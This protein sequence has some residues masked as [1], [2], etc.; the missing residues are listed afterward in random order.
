MAEPDGITAAVLGK[1]LPADRFNVA[2]PS[3]TVEQ[4][5]SAAVADR[6]EVVL[7]GPGFSRAGLESVITTLLAA[8]VRTLVL[9]GAALDEVSSRLLL[10]GASGFLLVDD[11][12]PESVADAVSTVAT[13]ST[14]LHPDVI[15]AVLQQ[16]RESR[17]APAAGR[18]ERDVH[19]AALTSRESEVLQGLM[20]GLTSR[21]L[22]NRLGVAEKTVEAHKSRLYAKLGARNQAHAVHIAAERGLL[23]GD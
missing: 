5:V 13:G 23:L 21:Q 19:T 14:A 17:A 6:T 18:V 12:T 10:A 4:L 20:D 16:W 8:G 7:I 1:A 3:V 9:S 2:R 11:A 15:L 22:A